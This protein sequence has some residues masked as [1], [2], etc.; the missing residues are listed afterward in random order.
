M[1]VI[2]NICRLHSV[3]VEL[4]TMLRSMLRSLLLLME[5]GAACAFVGL[6]PTGSPGM[7]AG[8]IR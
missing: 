7:T 8:T 2:I 1:H 5:I 4:T 6:L 3:G